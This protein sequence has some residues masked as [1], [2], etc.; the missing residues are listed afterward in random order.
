MTTDRPPSSSTTSETRTG[1][2][3]ASLSKEPHGEQAE[4]Y[5]GEKDPRHQADQIHALPD[6]SQRRRGPA[7][8]FLRFSRRARP[9]A[10]ESDLVRSRWTAPGRLSL[11]LQRAARVGTGLRLLVPVPRLTTPDLQPVG[12]AD[13]QDLAPDA[14]R[15][16][17]LLRDDHSALAVQLH[18][19]GVAEE[20][21][22]V[23]PGVLAVQRPGAHLLASAVPLL[24][25]E[26]EETAVLAERQVQPVAKR[27][28]ELRRQGDTALGVQLVPVLTE[29][30]RH[31]SPPPPLRSTFM[32]PTLHSVKSRSGITDVAF[33]GRRGAAT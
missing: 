10:A 19:L 18:P 33:S 9:R 7:H 2:C 12:H 11:G 30:L 20:H 13:H 26:G 32:P 17:E 23:R 25:G 27:L 14:D 8:P 28:P 21:P 22:R 6:L 24:L 4:T 1:T 16:A 29:Q 3:D 15:R 5:V 31:P